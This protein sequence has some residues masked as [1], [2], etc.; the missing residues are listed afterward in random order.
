MFIILTFITS[1]IALGLIAFIGITFE[2]VLIASL[3]VIVL[4]LVLSFLLKYLI[5]KELTII[6]DLVNRINE[7]D[8]TNEIGKTIASWPHPCSKN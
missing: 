6:G 4:S 8:L 3:A 7:N 2:S 5:S 1:L